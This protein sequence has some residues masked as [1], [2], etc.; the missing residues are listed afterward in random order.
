MFASRDQAEG[1]VE[2]GHPENLGKAYPQIVSYMLQGRPGEPV[3]KSVDVQKDG[4]QIARFIPVAFDN[5]SHRLLVGGLA[6]GGAGQLDFVW[7]LH[8]IADRTGL[9]A[10]AA[11]GALVRI[12]ITSLFAEG[13]CQI[14]GVTGKFLDFG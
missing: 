1:I 6:I 3:E 14:T 8:F 13:N 9:Q 7:K 12:D 4:K 2:A 10:D 11:T 5:I